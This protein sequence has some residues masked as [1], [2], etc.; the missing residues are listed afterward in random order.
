MKRINTSYT[1]SKKIKIKG[2]TYEKLPF[3]TENQKLTLKI[4]KNK[5]LIKVVTYTK[6]GDVDNNGNYFYKNEAKTGIHKWYYE[7]GELMDIGTYKNE[8]KQGTW[9]ASLYT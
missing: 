6:N 9:K 2:I 8:L 1:S 3:L 5:E 4:N 7:N